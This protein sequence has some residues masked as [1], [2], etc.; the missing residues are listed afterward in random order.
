MEPNH[1][2]VYFAALPAD[3]VAPQLMT[4]VQSYRDHLQRSG[5]LE[6]MRKSYNY[7]YGFSDKGNFTS[8]HI[9]SGGEGGGL[10]LIKV[11]HFRNNVQH[12]LN[13]TTSQRP[14]MECRAANSDVDSMAQTILGD[15]LLD[16]YMR[17]K[18]LEASLKQA[19][20]IALVLLEG[21]IE[22]EWD[23]ELGDEYG[24]DP[25][26]DQATGQALLDEAGSPKGKVVREGDL[27]YHVHTPLNVIRDHLKESS[28]HQDWVIIE[29]KKNKFDLAAQYP[30]LAQKILG[31]EVPQDQ[32][33]YS[34][35]NLHNETS[36]TDVPVFKFMH[37]KS[38]AM[39]E[40]RLVVFINSEIVLV[41]T[42][43]P[44]DN[45][46][47]GLP[48]YRICPSNFIG[49]TFG[50]SPGLDALSV[51]E[52]IDALY[53]VVITNQTNFG[54]QNIIAPKGHDIVYTRLAEGL[55]LV[56]Y[57]K[58]LGPPEPLELCKTPAEI[59]NF[60]PALVSDQRI[61]WG[62]NDVV[63]GDPQASLESGSAL[64]LVA[65][66][67]IQFNSGFQQSW[68][69]LIEDVG[70]GTLKMLQQFAVTERV[71]TIV[72]KHNR[73]YI[74]K[75]KGSDLKKINR[76]VVDM[77][78]PLSR[79]AAGRLEQANNLLNAQA[80]DARQY[81][82]VVATGRLDP[83]TEGS[84]S[85][86]MLI[87][88]EN[89]ALR[90]GEYVQAIVTE[91]HSVHIDEHF[92][93]LNSVSAKRDPKILKATLLHIQEHMVHLRTGDPAL[94][95][96]RGEVSLAMAPMG[97]DPSQQGA[98]Q[99]TMPEGPPAEKVPEPAI[100]GN[101]PSQPQ[102]PINP[103]SGNRYDPASGGL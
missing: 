44:Y 70:L 78:N 37:R 25:E 27:R 4:K 71:A 10:K 47:K 69:E 99:L 26:V 18:R 16:F 20:E 33:K 63:V 51:Q 66:Q 77:A 68:A 30:D 94:L 43:F 62:L 17:E 100:N 9:G 65:S 52:A 57:D 89:E 60:L 56:E 31:V 81:L 83:A 96:M 72:G 6:R 28:D 87:R 38:S 95:A 75:F 24:F 98:S 102:Q 40:G 82:A 48:V 34:L 76:V 91:R 79:T 12:V 74:E 19:A 73:A 15:G 13:M 85:E 88:D 45:C 8:S 35:R 3:E 11:N 7:Y 58:L 32:Q 101:L 86:L 92:I 5:L 59:F 29:T 80:I 41:D 67:A 1:S 49:T 61:L 103:M 55:N 97:P 50:Y 21:F 90:R 93:V 36:E 84:T 42:P 23:T 46:P 14:A 22:L 54:V 53:S 64:A 39:P 2:K